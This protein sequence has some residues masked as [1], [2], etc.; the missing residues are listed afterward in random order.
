V[1]AGRRV[2]VGG[3]GRRSPRRRR[4]PRRRPIGLSI[5][6]ALLFLAGL[7]G[8]HRDA[9]RAHGEQWS[10]AIVGFFVFANALN[11]VGQAIDAGLLL[12][13]DRPGTAG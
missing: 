10:V 4:G 2:A 8:I 7:V 9:D 3:R 11:A 13:R 5:V 6:P 12:M 1:A